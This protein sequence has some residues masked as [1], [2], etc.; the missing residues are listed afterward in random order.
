MH[1]CFFLSWKLERI[2]QRTLSVSD[3]I[4]NA[5]PRSS[6]ANFLKP[7]N[8]EK[9][10]LWGSRQRTPDTYKWTSIKLAPDFSLHHF[11][12]SKG[13]STAQE[14][15]TQLKSIMCQGNRCSSSARFQPLAFLHNIKRY[16]SSL[17]QQARLIY[18][19]W[20]RVGI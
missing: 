17:K 2:D 15:Y 6:L 13:R 4:K 8:R 19:E 3:K 7:K 12:V 11:V 14:F 16:S 20:R 10:L 1:R 18:P 5:T 9:N